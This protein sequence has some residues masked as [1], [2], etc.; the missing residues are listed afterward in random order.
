M[1]RFSCKLGQPLENDYYPK[2]ILI[3]KCKIVG[4]K[5]VGMHACLLHDIDDKFL[6][7]GAGACI[8]TE[9][10]QLLINLFPNC[11]TE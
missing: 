1:L 4:A 5:A 9:P 11:F 8:F 2:I 6:K 10:E 7:M 3:N